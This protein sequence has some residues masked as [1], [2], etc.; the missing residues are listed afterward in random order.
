MK[1]ASKSAIE[2]ESSANA[3]SK[4]SNGCCDDVCPP[5]LAEYPWP[6]RR[7]EREAERSGVE[8]REFG[9]RLRDEERGMLPSRGTVDDDI[10]NDSIGG[11][12]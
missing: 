6:S 10:L 5:P 7:D 12:G 9:A 1:F 8:G 3:G 2:S 4:A 11:E